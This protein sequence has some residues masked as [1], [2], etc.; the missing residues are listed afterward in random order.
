L[1]DDPDYVDDVD[2]GDD[3][4][5]GSSE[6]DGVDEDDEDAED[7]DEDEPPVK[8]PSKKRGRAPS[9]GGKERKTKKAKKEKT[10]TKTKKGGKKIDESAS[11]VSLDIQASRYRFLGDGEQRVKF[12]MSY[13]LSLSYSTSM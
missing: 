4:S 3:R 12:K 1:A 6:D 8:T 11:E 13:L 7:D 9:S 5:D 10:P 2:D